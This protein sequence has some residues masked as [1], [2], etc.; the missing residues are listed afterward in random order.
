MESI[1]QNIEEGYSSCDSI[2]SSSSN[3]DEDIYENENEH[4]I[5]WIN[6]HNEKKKNHDKLFT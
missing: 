1:D 2:I 3:D 5:S 6:D 4:I